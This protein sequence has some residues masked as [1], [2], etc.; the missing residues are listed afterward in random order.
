LGFLEEFAKKFRGKF[1]GSN[2]TGK[3]LLKG[4]EGA[5]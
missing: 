1:T 4:L 3:A 2:Y 5:L